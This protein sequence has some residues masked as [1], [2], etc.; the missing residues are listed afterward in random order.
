MGT[1][2]C[3]PLLRQAQQYAPCDRL[4]RHSLHPAED[5]RMMGHNELGTQLGGLLHHLFRD[6]QG[7]QNFAHLA[8]RPPHQESGVVKALL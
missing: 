6:I 5:H 7:H 3:D 4:I 8:A 2:G 1:D